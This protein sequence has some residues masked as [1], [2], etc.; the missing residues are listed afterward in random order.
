MALPKSAWG[1][2][3]GNN[4]LKAVKLV[5]S[6]DEIRVDDF[7]FIEHETIL[8]LAGD[9]REDLI[10]RALAT[11]VGRKNTRGSA[12][13]VGVSGQASFAR[14]IKLPPIEQKKIPEIVR[15]EAIQQIPFPL[16][17]VE[18]S[19][20]L[21]SAPD[22]PD[23]EVGL[24]AMRKE[25]VNQHVSLFTD[26]NL[27]VQVVQMNPLALYNAVQRD[28]RLDQGTAM[29]VDVGAETTDL[30]VASNASIWHR[31][32]P[33]GGNNFTDAITKAFKLP[34]SK[35]EELKRNAQTSK[36]TRQIYQ[37]M[38]PVFADLVAEIQRSVGFYGSVNKE[39]RITKVIAVGGT[40]KL[41]ALAK[42][43]NQN[44]QLDVER[45][46]ALAAGFPSDPKS[47]AEMSDHLLGLHTAYGLS[48]QAMGEAKVVSSLLPTVIRR[49]KI[50]KEKTKWFAA[51]AALFCAAPAIGLGRYFVEKIQFD[52]NAGLH[53]Q[54][55][56]ILSE[57][58]RLDAQWREISSA[59]TAE[60]QQIKN[61]QSLLN[62]RSLW[63][64]LIRELTGTIPQPPGELAAALERGD[65]DA[66]KKIP[67]NQRRIFRLD[68]LQSVYYPDVGLKVRDPRG[69]S[70]FITDFT[71]SGG[72]FQA[73][74]QP[75]GGR[76]FGPAGGEFGDRFGGEF[77]GGQPSEP[78]PDSAGLSGEAQRGFLV[79][80]LLISPNAEA[81]DEVDRE[82]RR[83]LMAI[84]TNAGDKSVNFAVTKVELVGFRQIRNDQNIMSRLQSE[85][86]SRQRLEQNANIDAGG[87]NPGGFRPGGFIP[88]GEFGPAGGE[89]GP[90]MGEG[91]FGPGGGF[92]PGGFNPGGG[93]LPGG[94][95]PGA[96]ANPPE[97]RDPITGESMLN[98]YVIEVLAAVVLDPPA[99]ADS[100]ETA[101][102]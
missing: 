13:A 73:P 35:A 24:F 71:S 2:D 43:L 12:V 56:A 60:L 28:G 61:V 99:P 91:R 22:S 21:F 86:Q 100:A 66:I 44:L 15:F 97:Y 67:R 78:S 98:D 55:Q 90:A 38:R 50:W 39:S 45:P 17:D 3:I 4:A 34:V 76:G 14:F 77:G 93:F 52:A 1:I 89:F 81:P 6:G 74:Q 59:G 46:D 19:Y 79:R 57:A 102:E 40:F 20:Q 36:Y 92:N 62:G 47:A 10:K 37:A 49:E 9:N 42:Y 54:A 72:S 58:Q 51:A 41:T 25:L 70:T 65:A 29:I 75:F 69:L 5:R 95:Q 82:V 23:V 7:D 88:G 68:S 11:F 84:R 53:D 94:S 16:D 63:P 27:D 48:L 26:A 96:D 18:W 87:F 80:M 31:S 83:R 32:I 85:Y 101:S 33:I 30:I 8:S 64:R